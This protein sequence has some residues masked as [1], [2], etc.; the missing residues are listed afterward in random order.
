M[1]LHGGLCGDQAPG[2]GPMLLITG[3]LCP[4]RTAERPRRGRR[5]V[6]LVLPAQEV[7]RCPAGSRGAAGGFGVGV[8]G[9]PVDVDV[10]AGGGT[11]GGLGLGPPGEVELQVDGDLPAQERTD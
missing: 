7:T 1:C 2:S 3:G 4:D 6:R 5:R 8:S 9:Q 10:V 11:A